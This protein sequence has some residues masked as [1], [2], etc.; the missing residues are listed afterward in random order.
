MSPASAASGHSESAYLPV[1]LNA[2]PA[3]DTCFDMLRAL[4]KFKTK[5]N[6]HQ[7]C[8]ERNQKEQKQG[9]TYDEASNL[10]KDLE[11]IKAFIEN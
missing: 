11:E 5:V 4:T 2:K 6:F 7:Y 10:I 9:C 8:D 1:L 3:V